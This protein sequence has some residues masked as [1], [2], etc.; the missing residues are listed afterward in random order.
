MAVTSGNPDLIRS[1]RDE[2]EINGSISF[3]RFME[4]ALYHPSL[5]F[6]ASDRARLGRAGDYFTNVSVGAAFAA[7]LGRQFVQL[8]K[9]MGQPSLFTVVEQGAHHGEFA[10]DLLQWS[11]TASPDFFGA[12]HYRIVEPAAALAK[13]QRVELGDFGGKVDWDDSLDRLVPFRGIF[14]SNELIDALPVH[15][16]ARSGEEWFQRRV[17][18]G[19]QGFEF[20]IEAIREEELAARVTAL[21]R[22]SGSYESEVSLAAPKW[23]AEVASRLERGFLIAVDYGFA[24]ED[25][26]SETRRAG[27][28][29]IRK[30]HRLLPS[31]FE[32]IGEA[33][34]TAHVEWSSLIQAGEQAGLKFLGL[35]DQHHFLTG[36]LS[37]D[38]DFL[39]QSDA[40]TRRQLQTLLHP[41][42]LGR[43]F[44]ALVMK[45]GVT[46]EFQV[47]GLKFASGMK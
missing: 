32:E 45:G 41:E 12:L 40:K 23:I 10:R 5:G 3:A 6:Y 27:T 7:L 30:E 44:Q 28:L 14:F 22:F 35:P 17:R 15:L 33:D 9:G 21:P 36:I 47:D 39:T 11:A 26:Y 43:S 18:L 38:P 31:P 24:A 1:L 25:Y 34:I 4:L 8:W 46:P 19:K 16:I 2:I 37:G 13:R 42:M 29:Q 20:G